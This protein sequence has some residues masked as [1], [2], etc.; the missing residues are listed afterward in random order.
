MILLHTYYTLLE[1]PFRNRVYRA[2]VYSVLILTPLPN[3]ALAIKA[4]I[5]IIIT[6]TRNAFQ[7][8]TEPTPKKPSLNASHHVVNRI[9]G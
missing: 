5:T 3:R 6:G 8:S 4:N 1:K 9:K 2:S 7:S